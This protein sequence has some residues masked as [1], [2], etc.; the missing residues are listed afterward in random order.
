MQVAREGGENFD[1]SLNDQLYEKLKTL[2]K[3]YMIDDAGD[4]NVLTL[5]VPD[6]FKTDFRRSRE[7]YKRPLPSPYYV[8]TH[9]P[10]PTTFQTYD[11]P[12]LI[13]PGVH[14]R[15]L[16]NEADELRQEAQRLQQEQAE[17]EERLALID[18]EALSKLSEE[19]RQILESKLSLNER[20]ALLTKLEDGQLDEILPREENRFGGFGASIGGLSGAVAQLGASAGGYIGG[21]LAGTLGA[22]LGAAAGAYLGVAAASRFVKKT[23][24]APE[25]MSNNVPGDENQ[26]RNNQGSRYGATYGGYGATL[27]NNE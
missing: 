10:F 19:D 1:L 23:S 7:L 26:S 11:S 15:F 20:E 8:T 25:V 9:Y 18:R 4:P 16:I 2:A 24:R 17:R 13:N 22:K 3:K 21:K 5:L 27:V 6:I 14:T 12:R